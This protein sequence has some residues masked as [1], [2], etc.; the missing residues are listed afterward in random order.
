MRGVVSTVLMSPPTPSSV[1]RIEIAEDLWPNEN[2]GDKDGEQQ[3]VLVLAA[4]VPAKHR[5]GE[6]DEETGRD[7]SNRLGRRLCPAV[8]D[9]AAGNFEFCSHA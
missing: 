4:H 8:R 9:R 7:R 1:G 5:L 3:R 6:P 2:R